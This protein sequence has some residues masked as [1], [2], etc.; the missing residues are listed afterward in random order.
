MTVKSGVSNRNKDLFLHLGG[1]PI[2]DFCNTI[3]FHGEQCEDHLMSKADLLIFL[4]ETYDHEF[5]LTSEQFK[6][7]LKFRELLRIFFNELIVK[8]KI[9]KS[10]HGVNIWLSEIPLKIEIENLINKDENLTKLVSIQSIQQSE[11]KLSVSFFSFLNQMS[12]DR[13]KKCANPNCSHFFYD[14]S[15]SKTRNWC[16]MKS[17]GNLMKARSFYSRSKEK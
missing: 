10:I 6:S 7:L 11:A 1:D 16:S 15:K 5:T 14:S 4:K 8:K 17:C 9:S 13:L 3:V 12:L 2:L